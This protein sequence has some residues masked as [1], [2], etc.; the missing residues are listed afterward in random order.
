MS[1]VNNPNGLESAIR[2]P[3]IRAQQEAASKGFGKLL[4][5]MAKKGLSYDGEAYFID[6][7]GVAHYDNTGAKVDTAPKPVRGVAVTPPVAPPTARPTFIAPPTTQPAA[8]TVEAIVHQF[9]VYDPVQQQILLTI[10]NQ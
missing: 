6:S 8:I 7:D 1:F 4:A 3:E 2:T 9:K 10:L 5:V